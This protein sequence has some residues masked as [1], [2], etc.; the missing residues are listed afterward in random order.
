MDPIL[1]P[2]LWMQGSKASGIFDFLISQTR[3]E[4]NEDCMGQ[5]RVPSSVVH[6]VKKVFNQKL[7]NLEYSLSS[8]TVLIWS[9]EDYFLS[10]A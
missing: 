6:I 4:W 1:P 2:E 9:W 3:G 8:V 10:W 5:S 7:R